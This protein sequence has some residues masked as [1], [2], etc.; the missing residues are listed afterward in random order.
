MI[1]SKKSR[2]ILDVGC[3]NGEMTNRLISEGY[4]VYGTDGAVTGIEIAKKK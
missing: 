2:T 3:G 1:G 4:N